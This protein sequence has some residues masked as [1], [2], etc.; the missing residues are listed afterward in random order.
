MDD[1]SSVLETQRAHLHAKW[2]DLEREA[3]PTVPY[4]QSHGLAHRFSGTEQCLE[5]WLIRINCTKHFNLS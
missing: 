5:R 3:V 1:Q 4:G 2:D